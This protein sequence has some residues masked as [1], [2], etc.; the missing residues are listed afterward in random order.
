[1]H[2]RYAPTTARTRAR[3]VF[4]LFLAA[5]SSFACATENDTTFGYNYWPQGY[6]GCEALSTA[7]KWT[8]AQKKIAADLDLMR[9]LGADTLRLSFYME[10]SGYAPGNAPVPGYCE[11]LPQM[12]D[13]IES[14]GFK[15]VIAFSNTYL[16]RNGSGG[17]YWQSAALP[18][19]NNASG[20]WQ[21][22]MD[23]K[24]WV[25]RIVELTGNRSSVL[26][27]DLQNEYDSTLQ[28]GPAGSPGGP[29]LGIDYYFRTMY[30]EVTEI[31]QAKRGISILR[32]PQ[33]I[34]SA[35]WYGV[36]SQLQVLDGS[37]PHVEF[38]SY[39]VV[40]ISRCPLHADVTSVKAQM[41]AAFPGSTILLGEFGRRAIEPTAPTHPNQSVTCGSTPNPS[42]DPTWSEASQAETELAL[43]TSAENAGIKYL[44][45][46]LWDNTPHS[47]SYDQ[48]HADAQAY[49]HGYDPHKP[50][51]MIGWLA[52]RHGML[53]NPDIEN[54][55]QIGQAPQSWDKGSW[56]TTGNAPVTSL[57]VSGGTGSGDASTRSHYLRLQSDQACADC[58]IWAKADAV[59]VVPGMRLHINAF[60][61]SNLQQVKMSVVQY[62]AAWN[63]VD[64]TH[65]PA[66]DPTGWS[67]NN[68]MVRVHE[69]DPAN[70]STSWNVLVKPNATR[71][72][73]TIGGTPA[74][75]PA[76][77]DV[78]TVSV[79]AR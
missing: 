47:A 8:G 15:V 74:Q 3:L 13:L 61:R 21:F 35:N 1:M 63:V 2:S 29:T 14:A 54:A 6:A 72:I 24:A 41:A 43:M 25:K 65:A 19:G 50:K 68:Y 57:F 18:Y 20:F 28:Y 17:Y 56:A 45:W 4:G 33:D 26:Y 36:P 67:W 62:D 59:D 64:V 32:A 73:V 40:P 51:D 55:P 42:A 5:A 58:L 12:L 78:D 22:M 77:L 79:F 11:Y 30:S 34:D 16:L 46:M 49:A 76:I 52:Q 60:I 10:T 31:P 23:S 7:Q 38:H 66:F 69:Q 9:S 53:A 48:H 44:H 27:F 71:A 39:P 37:L 75:A 70:A